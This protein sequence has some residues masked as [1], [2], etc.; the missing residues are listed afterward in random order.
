MPASIT[1]VTTLPPTNTLGDGDSKQAALS[2]EGRLIVFTSDALNLSNKAFGTS[3]IYLKN[4]GTGTV[5]LLSA[6]ATG[7]VA[8]SNSSQP[9]ISGDGRLVVFQSYA[10][11]LVAN[12]TNNDSDVFLKDTQTGTLKLLSATATGKVG[13][14]WSGNPD[15]SSD[16]RYGVFQSQAS[17]LVEGDLNGAFD[18]FM[19]DLQTNVIT[20]LTRNTDL[21]LGNGDSVTPAISADGRYVAFASDASNLVANDRN[22]TRDVFLKNTQTGEI[23]LISA[24]G[25]GAAGYGLSDSPSISADGT[26]VAFRSYATDLADV[27]NDGNADIYVRDLTTGTMKVVSQGMDGK[28][29]NG[30]SFDPV[31]SPNGRYVAF[32]SEATNLIPSDSNDVLD[33]FVAD[34]TTGAISRVDWIG[35]VVGDSVDPAFSGDSTTLAFSHSDNVSTNVYTWV[36]TV[37]P[38]TLPVLTLSDNVRVNEGNSGISNAD[39]TVTLSATSTQPVTVTYNTVDGTAQASSDY[40]TTRGNLTFAPGETRKTISVPIMGDTS[41]ETDETLQVVLSAPTNATL[42]NPSSRTITVVNDDIPQSVSL[43]VF[44]L[45]S[46]AV[47]VKEGNTGSM[48]SAVVMVNLSQASTQQ[49]TVDY[50]TLDDTALEEDDYTAVAGTLIFEA[51]QTR[52]SINIPINGDNIK[53]SNESFMLFLT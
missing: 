25:L 44:S 38:V 8:D 29:A 35:A 4:T 31:I 36:N 14:G 30:N 18:I 2:L 47:S 13:D 32:V 46:S 50:S 7:T 52:K 15:M 49:I 28:S 5:T 41:V 33:V 10:S 42:S 48:G 3:N 6:T 40:T 43:P 20:L 22:A 17:N 12:D 9:D 1:P 16:G 37:V 39:V 21:L 53:E 34:L 45:A 26:K 24:N 27:E 19:R 51:G 23:T 11:N